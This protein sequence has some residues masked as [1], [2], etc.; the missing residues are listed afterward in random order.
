MKEYPL[1]YLIVSNPSFQFIAYL[2][3]VKTTRS[4]CQQEKRKNERFIAPE[5]A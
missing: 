3:G 1:L 4:S 5:I 2:L